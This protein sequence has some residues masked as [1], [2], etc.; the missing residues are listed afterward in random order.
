[1]R[2]GLALIVGV[3]LVAAAMGEGR[4]QDHDR[5]ALV[6]GNTAYTD[7]NPV[8]TATVDARSLSRTLTDLGFVVEEAVDFDRRR[9]FATIG[10]FSDRAADAEIAVIAYFG[11]A[12]HD[13]AQTY[14]LPIDLRLGDPSQWSADAIPLADVLTAAG[15]GSLGLVLLDASRQTGLQ[16]EGAAP[17]LGEPGALPPGVVA[18]FAAAPGVALEPD[19]SF[20]SPYGAALVDHVAAED[21]PLTTVFERIAETVAARTGGAQQPVTFGALDRLDYQLNP[22]PDVIVA[23]AEPNAPVEPADAV[24]ADVEGDD[25]SAAAA[26]AET[27]ADADAAAAETEDAEQAPD[28][29]DGSA[30]A[31]ADPDER[32]QTGQDQTE[33]DAGDPGFSFGDEGEAQAATDPDTAADT[34][35]D[36][37]AV[38]AAQAPPP[39]ATLD[40]DLSVEERRAIQRSLTTIGLYGARIDAIFGS[41]TRIGIRGFQARIGSEPTGYLSEA[42]IELLHE[43]AAATR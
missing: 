13:A 39:S 3:L 10:A 23:E 21:T 17:G 19:F 37:E 30:A 34:G 32:G 15:A 38:A 7:L 16:A 26:A 28:A 11:L 22:A 36:T 41:L 42:Q 33:P 14:L 25:A 24:S 27:V 43:T 5:V 2:H 6:I 1:M 20:Q 12:Q 8:R 35:A 31:P 9:L 4:A 29:A 40:P 18:S